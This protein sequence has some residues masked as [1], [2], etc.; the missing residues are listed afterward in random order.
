L[1]YAYGKGAED[2]T[3]YDLIDNT[4]ICKFVKQGIS[5]NFKN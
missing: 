2:L 3:Q 5:N 4:S 1:V